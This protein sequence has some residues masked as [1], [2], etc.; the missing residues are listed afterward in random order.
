MPEVMQTRPVARIGSAQ[1]D[2]ARERVEG[3]MDV[4]DV[5]DS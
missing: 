5:R 4:A 1:T 2:L 3:S